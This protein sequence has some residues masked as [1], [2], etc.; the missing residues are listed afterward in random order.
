MTGSHHVPEKLARA[1]YGT[2]KAMEMG[3]VPLVIADEPEQSE[4]LQ[5]LPGK[6]DAT[7]VYSSAPDAE[8]QVRHD[9]AHAGYLFLVLDEDIGPTLAEFVRY[10]LIRRDLLDDAD[11]IVEER[12]GPAAIHDGHRLALVCDRTMSQRL[13]S[14]IR[15]RVTAIAA[16]R[17]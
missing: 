5:F 2:V 16:I 12:A 14:W 7:V 9:V 15:E 17:A 6:L 10:Y 1:V 13:Q 11:A 4:Y 3:E 8:A